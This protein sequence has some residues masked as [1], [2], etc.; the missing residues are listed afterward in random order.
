MTNDTHAPEAEKRPRRP[1]G[2]ALLALCFYLFGAVLLLFTPIAPR[3]PQLASVVPWYIYLA[4][5][6]YFFT[7]GWG[8][9]GARR[10]AYF[11]ALAMCAVSAYYVI[12]FAALRDSGTVLSLGLLSLIATYLLLPRVRAE[13]MH[14]V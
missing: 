5:A 13:F 6:L 3:L 12:S 14:N 8:V 11:A 9:W 7:L 1:A 2:I 4:G 10:W